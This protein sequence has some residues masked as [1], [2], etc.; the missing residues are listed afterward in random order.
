MIPTIITSRPT[1]EMIRIGQLLTVHAWSPSIDDEHDMV[2]PCMKLS[3]NFNDL[4]R[5]LMLLAVHDRP[6]YSAS[7][8][9]VVAIGVACIFGGEALCLLGPIAYERQVHLVCHAI[10]YGGIGLVI[11]G[12]A[13][14]LRSR[15]QSAHGRGK[16]SQT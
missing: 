5:C 11:F 7:H 16:E 14:H 10:L 2:S 1:I 8:A 9:R 15:R 6:R 3:R 12:A 4:A 13:L